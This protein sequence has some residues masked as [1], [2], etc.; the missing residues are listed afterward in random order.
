VRRQ[1]DDEAGA[2]AALVESNALL[3]AQARPSVSAIV[4]NGVVLALVQTQRLRLPEAERTY[5]ETL[6]LTLQR[7]GEHH[8]DTVHVRAR[9]GLFLHRAGRR[10]EAWQLLDAAQDSV[11]SHP[12]RLTLSSMRVA[13]SNRLQALVAEGAYAEARALADTLAAEWARLAQGTAPSYVAVLRL[14]AEQRAGQG[15][16]AGARAALDLAGQRLAALPQDT[17]RQEAP[18]VALMAARLELLAQRPE[19]ALQPLDRMDLPAGDGAGL[20]AG[21]QA[22][23]LRAVALLALGRAD[24]S[25]TVASQALAQLQASPLRDTPELQA[26]LLLP[27]GQALQQLGRAPE[28]C[29]AL[30]RATGLRLRALGKA[31]PR[32][33]QARAAAAACTR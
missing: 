19:A 12:D 10:D 4:T 14:Q 21:L 9:Y 8:A 27:Q 22:A 6:A 23:A 29:D 24:E 17:Q 7:N 1:L 31:S 5:R 26:D 28:A 20:R 13:R 18:G 30:G 25:L 33:A 2:E 3:Q 15:D 32:V 11:Q 16:L